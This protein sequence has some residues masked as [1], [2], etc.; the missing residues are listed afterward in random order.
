MP[1]CLFPESV[2]LVA[3]RAPGDEAQLLPEEAHYVATARPK[4]KQE[5]AAGRWCARAALSRLGV[6]DFPLR[7]S[8]DRQPLWPEGYRGSITHT[9]GLCMAAVASGARILALGLDSEVVGAPT[10]DLWQTIGRAE[11]LAWIDSLPAAERPAAV[12]LLFSAKESLYKCQYPLTGE[13]LD[14]HDLLL[15]APDWGAPAGPFTLRP[16]RRIRFADLA[17]M[18]VAGR[19]VFHEEFVSTGIA[20]PA[21]R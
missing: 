18:P 19:Y 21:P 8:P 1:P 10:P 13:W 15:E 2:I 12:T 20:I 5:F 7:A 6:H 9:A 11:E 3:R 16:T 14:F 17:A 4:R